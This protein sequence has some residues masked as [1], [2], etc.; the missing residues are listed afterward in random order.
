MQE[1]EKCLLQRRL[2]PSWV[3]RAPYHHQGEMRDSL[4][5]KKKRAWWSVHHHCKVKS[6]ISSDLNNGT[7]LM[8]RGQEWE[9]LTTETFHS[10]GKK[11]LERVKDSQLTPVHP[12]HTG[13]CT[14]HRKKKE[15]PKSC[16]HFKEATSVLTACRFSQQADPYLPVSFL[17][18]AR[19]SATDLQ[20]PPWSC[21][22]VSR[23]SRLAVFTDSLLQ[24]QL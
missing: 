8:S 3:R 22:L 17:F 23:K 19:N 9:I 6:K 18:S 2:C 15:T 21:D 10:K 7:T 11:E 5:E 20:L 1:G 13:L 12:S 14:L 4:K 16:S 24:R